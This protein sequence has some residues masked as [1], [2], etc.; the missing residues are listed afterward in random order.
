ML[1][2]P[3]IRFRATQDAVYAVTAY[4][5]VAQGKLGACKGLKADHCEGVDLAKDSLSVELIR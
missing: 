1:M 3:K 5:H 4:G 2:R